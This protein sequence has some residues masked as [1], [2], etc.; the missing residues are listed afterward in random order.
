MVLQITRSLPIWVEW[1]EAHL[2]CP[3]EAFLVS[4]P[5]WVE[6]IEAPLCRHTRFV[7]FPSLPIWVEWI[8]A[9]Q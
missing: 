3:E 7:L 4:L 8:E 1:I 2:V 9:Q 5:I 6:W